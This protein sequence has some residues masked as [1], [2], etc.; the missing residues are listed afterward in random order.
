MKKFVAFVMI[1][2]L[3][4]FCAVGCNKPAPK[5]ECPKEPVE[6]KTGAETAAP[7]AAEE[8]KAPEAAKPAEE[9]APEKA[10]EK[11]LS[12]FTGRRSQF[13]GCTVNR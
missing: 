6:M 3:G 13:I 10:A 1:L 4:L 5:K 8:P 2:S 12:R 7:K 9:K 11:K